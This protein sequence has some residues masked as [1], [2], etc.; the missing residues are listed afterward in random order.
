MA[1]LIELDTTGSLSKF[2]PALDDDQQEFRVLYAS[3]RLRKWLEEVLPKLRS[4]WNIEVTPLEQFDA[5]MEAYASGEPLVFQHNF[6]PISHVSGYVW[7][8]KTPDLRIFGW[9]VARD[10]FVGVAADTTDRIKLHRLYHGY[11]GEVAHFLENL[12]LDEPKFIAGDDPNAV[13]SN[14]DYP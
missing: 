1:T 13:V 6:Y 10:C 9:F 3:P 5:L 8:L 2:D 12:D 7:E 14:F 11:A 4:T